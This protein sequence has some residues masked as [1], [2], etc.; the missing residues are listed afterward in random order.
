DH[1]EHPVRRVTEYVVIEA[2]QQ[3]DDGVAAVP[4]VDEFMIRQERLE[5]VE[6]AAAVAAPRE[7]VTEEDDFHDRRPSI[8]STIRR[9]SSPSGKLGRHNTSTGSANWGRTAL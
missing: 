2:A 5:F 8:A 4:C 9:V 1:D 7:T 6:V 3:I